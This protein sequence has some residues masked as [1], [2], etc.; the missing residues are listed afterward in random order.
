MREVDQGK[1][2]ILKLRGWQFLFYPGEICEVFRPGETYA[3]DG[4]IGEF[5]GAWN[6]ADKVHWFYE[7]EFGD[8]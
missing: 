2:S 5:F 6:L 1:L 7:E 3:V 4:S 8:G